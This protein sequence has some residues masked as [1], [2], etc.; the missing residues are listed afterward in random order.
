[1]QADLRRE[2]AAWTQDT[3]RVEHPFTDDIGGPI[4]NT[5]LEQVQQRVTSALNWR[6]ARQ[7]DRQ[8]DLEN[9]VLEES[10]KEKAKEK[11]SVQSQ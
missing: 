3:G 4:P 6:P 8:G 9:G 5:Q 2:K 11:D 1:M 10:E 7:G